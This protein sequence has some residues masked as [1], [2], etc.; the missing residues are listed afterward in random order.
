MSNGGAYLVNPLALKKTKL[1][2]GQR[3]SLEDDLLPAIMAH[4]SKLYGLEFTGRFIDIGLPK[5][6]F[7]ATEVMDP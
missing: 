1:T 2:P 6:Y 4:G 7:R 3:L 5:D